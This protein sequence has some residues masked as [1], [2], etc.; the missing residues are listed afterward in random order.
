MTTCLVG[1]RF[2][3]IVAPGAS[4]ERA[5][6]RTVAGVSSGVA[7]S[8]L[9]LRSCA[10]VMKCASPTLALTTPTVPQ[11]KFFPMLPASPRPAGG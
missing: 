10:G 7:S 9:A 8:S 1:L 11:R 2:L 5:R 4:D 3:K 6:R